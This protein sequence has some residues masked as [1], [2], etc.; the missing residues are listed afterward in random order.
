MLFEYKLGKSHRKRFIWIMTMAVILSLAIF[1]LVFMTIMTIEIHMLAK[2]RIHYIALNEIT[3]DAN[4]TLTVNSILRWEK[5][6]IVDLNKPEND[7]YPCIRIL[8][9]QIPLLQNYYLISLTR[10]GK[11]GEFAGMFSEL[12]NELGIQNRI[13]TAEH[14]D[15]RDHA[16]VEIMNGNETTPIETT[17][18]SGYNDSH[19]YDCTWLIKYRNI[20]VQSTGEDIS[21]KYYSWCA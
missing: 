16:W 10:C 19:F 15:G 5:E 21:K 14:I 8:P 2:N 20:R 1:I 4:Q 13:I 17:S 11:C 12:A 7:M 9:G 18:V 6:N 3:N